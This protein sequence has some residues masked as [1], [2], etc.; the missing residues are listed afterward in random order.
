MTNSNLQKIELKCLKDLFQTI[1]DPNFTFPF[2]VQRSDF[3]FHPQEFQQFLNR[4]LLRFCPILTIQANVLQFA[5][6]NEAWK[7]EFCL[8][9]DSQGKDFDDPF[10]LVSDEKLRDFMRVQVEI[11]AHV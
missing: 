4:I 10:I 2:L 5:P 7:I 8:G 1:C 9:H 6:F 11:L 3:Q